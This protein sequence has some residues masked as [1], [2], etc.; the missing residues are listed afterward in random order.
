[1]AGS[2]C[3]NCTLEG[4]KAAFYE[5]MPRKAFALCARVIKTVKALSKKKII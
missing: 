2:R 4:G 5:H 3:R 1:M